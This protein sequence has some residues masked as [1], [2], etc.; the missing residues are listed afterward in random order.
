MTRKLDDIDRRL[1]LELQRDAGQ[2]QRELA[3]RI[4]LSQ[5]AC[6][7]R[8]KLLQEDGFLLGQTVRVNCDALGLGLVVFMMVKTRNHSG[9]WL[10]AFRQHVL[11]IPE[12]TDFYRIGGEYDYMLKVTTSDMRN[13]DRIYQILIQK[14][15][16]EKVTSYFS[17]EAIAEGRPI[18]P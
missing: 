12:V 1:L 11:S 14:L 8:I 5:N 15:D 13:Y 18:E 17:M 2:T 10:E 7:R 6:W 4:G 16:L 9:T 3:D